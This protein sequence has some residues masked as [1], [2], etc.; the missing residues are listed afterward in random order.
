[1]PK[2]SRSA[3]RRVWVLPEWVSIPNF[4]VTTVDIEFGALVTCNPPTMRDGL[5]LRVKDTG[6]LVRPGSPDCPFSIPWNGMLP[7]RCHLTLRCGGPGTFECRRQMWMDTRSRPA[8]CGSGLAQFHVVRPSLSTGGNRLFVCC[9][10]S[11]ESP[12]PL[13]FGHRSSR[14]AVLQ[15]VSHDLPEAGCDETRPNRGPATKFVMSHPVNASPAA[16][17]KLRNF[18]EPQQMGPRKSST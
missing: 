13:G 10:G 11:I 15:A 4:P 3:L 6:G 1:M 2:T 7:L 9:I 17:D 8:S 12:C 18:A 16:V 14:P 5:P